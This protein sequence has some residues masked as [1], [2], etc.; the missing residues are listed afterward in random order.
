MHFSSS[1]VPCA[2]DGLMINPD[3][4]SPAFQVKSARAF[5]TD[6]LLEA[7]S[8]SPGRIPAIHTDV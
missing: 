7:Q 4:G 1:C 5:A 2:A 3:I 6:R 8:Q